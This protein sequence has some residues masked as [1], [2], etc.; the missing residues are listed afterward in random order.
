MIMSS[1]DNR[2]YNIDLP[3]PYDM[4]KPYRYIYASHGLGGNGDDITRES[5]YG[6]KRTADA[7]ND[8]AIFIAPSGIG[9]SWGQKDHPLFDDILAFVKQNV[10]V[11]TT[12]VFMTGFSFG[13]MYSYSL[14]LNHQKDI[15]A[16]IGIGPANYNIW[17][18]PRRASRSL[19]CKRPG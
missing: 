2:H 15:R 14:S 9:G 7:A 8:P 19:G 11:D 17:L 4:N 6:L 3:S 16:A 10:C 12:R 18:P 1:G 5:Y 13:G